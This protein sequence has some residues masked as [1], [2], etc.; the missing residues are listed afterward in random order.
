MKSIPNLVSV[1]V[2]FVLWAANGLAEQSGDFAFSINISDP[3]TVTITNYTG[4]SASLT[5]PSIIDG[6][7]VTRLGNGLFARNNDLRDV[8][9]QDGVSS[10]GAGAF[11]YCRYMTNVVMTSSI[12]N[13]EQSAFRWCY[14]LKSI[15]LS[16]GIKTINQETF[17][18]CK[19]LTD[20]TIP[21]GVVSL[22][23][24]A[25]MSCTSLEEITIPNGVVS[26]DMQAFWGCKKL[27]SIDLPDSVTTLGIG[28]FRYCDALSTVTISGDIGQIGRYTFG[29][30]DALTNVTINGDV[31]SIAEYAFSG[32]YSLVDIVLPDSLLSIG[33]YAFDD[34]SSLTHIAI[35]SG[36]TSIGSRPFNDCISLTHIAIP[37]GVTSIGS[38]PF[39]GCLSL[40]SIDVDAEN[41]YYASANGV[42]LD[43]AET[44]LLSYPLGRSGQY[45]IPSGI[46]NIYTGAFAGCSSLS[47][48]TIPESVSNIGYGAFANCGGLTHACFLGEAPGSFEGNVFLGTAA[49]FSIYYMGNESG[50]TSPTWQGYPAKAVSNVRV[51]PWLH[52]HGFDYDTSLDQDLNKDGVSLLMA[53]SLNL[54]PTINL[55]DSL[56]QAVCA[57]GVMS[58]TYYAARPEITYRVESSED[59][60]IWRTNSVMVSELDSN[61]QCIATMDMTSPCGFLRLQVEM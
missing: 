44:V 34:C 5:V 32:C 37:S 38:R 7:R 23:A 26:V 21:D 31:T 24:N 50:F 14:D 54:D 17:D 9:I 25:F 57:S 33:N 29:Y 60:R 12:T 10:I 30:C 39:D 55:A 48:I 40:L 42:L 58:I 51:I 1:T 27:K 49:E 45:E 52:E 36:V 18:R 35:P 8:T 53:Y 6:K 28:T 2:L 15:T 19:D 43:K 59:M 4:S 61:N 47:Y 46:T 11:T 16:T 20:I 56:P 3:N 22:G 41:Q 13:I